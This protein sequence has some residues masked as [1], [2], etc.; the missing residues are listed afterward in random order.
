MSNFDAQPINNSGDNVFKNI[1]VAE[2]EVSYFQ[3]FLDSHDFSR[4]TVRAFGFD[5]CKFAKFFF[6]VNNERYDTTRVTTTDITSFKR[7][8]REDLGQSVSTVNRAL[9][10]VRK[11]LGWFLRF[12]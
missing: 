10:S 5:L 8:L 11:Y 9:V 12:Q 7:H 6:S 4:H 1:P 2:K 3:Q